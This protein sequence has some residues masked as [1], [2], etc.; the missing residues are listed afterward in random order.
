MESSH[1]VILSTSGSK[2]ITKFNVLDCISLNGTLFWTGARGRIPITVK[3]EIC[4]TPKRST[5]TPGMIYSLY[6]C[7]ERLRVVQEYRTWNGRQTHHYLSNISSF[8]LTSKVRIPAKA[9]LP[10]ISLLSLLSRFFTS[11]LDEFILT[12]KIKE[13]I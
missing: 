6:F 7:P 4:N 2:F 9:H 10:L 12:F 11:V 8:V 5:F 1:L 3:T 13:S